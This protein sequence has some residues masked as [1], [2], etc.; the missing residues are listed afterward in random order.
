MKQVYLCNSLGKY[1]RIM[2]ISIFLMF[3]CI[4]VAVA[5]TSYS[6]NT[7]LSLKVKNK[8]L[9]D[10]F[11]QIEN[12]SEYIFFYDDDAVNLNKRVDVSVENAPIAVV[13]DKVLDKK[14]S[15]YEIKNRQVVIYKNEEEEKASSVLAVK[16]TEQTKVSVSGKV[17][18]NKGEALIGVSVSE[19]GT[20]NGV[21]TDIDGNY[22]ISV[23]DAKSTLV[24]RYLGHQSSESVVGTQKVINVSLQAIESSLD[25]VIVVAYGT[26][27]KSSVTGAISVVNADKLTTLVTPNVNVMLQ[28]KVPGV[29][30]LGTSGKPGE[31]ASIRIRGKGTLTSGVDPLWVIDG[32]VAGT[33][34]QLNPNEIETISVLKDA[35]ATALYGSRATNGVILVTTKNGKMGEQKVNVSAKVGIA[36][37]DLG[38]FKLMNSRQLY[39]YTTSMDKLDG[40][41][42]LDWFN[43]D[44]LKHDT[45]WFDLATKTAIAQNYTLSYTTGTEKTKSF[46]SADYYDEEGT[47]RGY[48]FNRFS[49]RSNNDYKISNKFTLRTKLA[50]AYTTIAD[51]QHS[52]S[53]AMTYLPWDF[54][55]NPDGTVRTG[56]EEDWHGRDQSNYLYNLQWNW[57]REKQLGVTAIVGLDYK[58]TDYLMF[59]SNNN[60]GY[61][62]I[63][64]EDYEDPRSLGAEKYSGS[65]TNKN[66]FYT[67]RYTNQL[68]R[69]NKIFNNVH[70]VSSFLGY[71]YSDSKSETNNATKQGLTAG[72]EV[73]DVAVN[74][75]SISG[76]KNEWAMQSYYF[77]TNYTYNDKY[78]GQF[79]Y[80]VDG[81]SRF[82]KN[83]RYG[84]FYTIGGA[85]SIHN[86]DFM[87]EFSFVDQLKLRG[88]YGSIGNTPGG[89][90]YGYLSVYTLDKNYA[91]VPGSF[92]GILGNYNLT[93]EKC[94]ETNIAIDARLFDRVGFSVDFYNKNTSDL[95]YRVALSTLTG[96]TAQYRNIGAVENRGVEISLS[97]DIIKTKDFLWTIDANIGFN[98]NRIKELYQGNVQI[99]GNKIFEEGQPLDTWYLPEW[100]GVDMYTGDPMWYIVNKDGSKTLTTNITE[101]TLQKHGSANPNITGGIVSTLTYKGLTLSGVFAFVSGN[102]IYHYAREFYDNDGAYITYNSMK[103]KDG[104]NRWEKPGD[105]ASH[106][107]PVAGGNNASNKPSSRYLEDGSFFR[108]NNLTLAYNLPNKFVRNLGIKYASISLS[109]ENVFTIT[110]FSGTDVELGSSDKSG[111]GGN[112]TAGT[113]LYPMARRFAMGVNLTF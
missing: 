8:T 66:A 62:Y 1:L 24:F 50:G 100:A 59:E 19:K 108:M 86:E 22:A 31:A 44:L 4:G 52:L 110:N 85:W 16:E 63:Y 2:K 46:I 25:E 48:D 60:I 21:L 80:R 38:K 53:S 82:G 70:N 67:T 92:P 13:L 89:G 102:Q 98:R 55:H 113:D 93:W 95:L 6:Q 56:K 96:Y 57:S 23:K 9:K 83:S 91:G 107:R 28:G 47:V 90:D 103:L 3:F 111:G 34:A 39:D 37:Q 105:I 104:W 79:S 75:F 109:A 40:S 78:M 18:D 101:A 64:G 112:G 49:L 88:S 43:E 11:S 32:V 61:R 106:P 51:R 26:Q 30:V 45:D 54:P 74:P 84:G 29:Q 65:I 15:R 36:Y 76:G 35:G 77:N 97:P 69:L 41:G 10:V 17:T 72:T 68:L 99:N 71:E 27:K 5:G 33:G 94:F 7:M 81:S 42:I 87:K 12:Q 20:T 14:S 73:F 58:I